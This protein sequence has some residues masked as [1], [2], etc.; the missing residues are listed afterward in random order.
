MKKK[1]R[2]LTYSQGNVSATE[3]TRAHAFV[4]CNC[5]YLVLQYTDIQEFRMFTDKD[6]ST[7]VHDLIVEPRERTACRF[8]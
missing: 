6:N 4:F 7:W 2:E 5:A 1:T 8:I 3:H